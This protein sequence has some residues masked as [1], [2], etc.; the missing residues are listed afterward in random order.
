ML[1]EEVSKEY[2]FNDD[3]FVIGVAFPVASNTKWQL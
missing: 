2:G 3:Y 1:K